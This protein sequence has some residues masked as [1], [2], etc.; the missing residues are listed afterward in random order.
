MQIHY[1]SEIDALD[2]VL[3]TAEAVDST[4]LADSMTMDVDANGN[5]VSIEILDATKRLGPDSLRSLTVAGIPLAS[6]IPA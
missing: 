1:D 5:P 2:I 4:D 3:S 6:A